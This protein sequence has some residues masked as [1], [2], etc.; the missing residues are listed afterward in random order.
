[1]M[2]GVKV[3]VTPGMIELGAKEKE[4]NKKFGEQIAE[5][6]EHNLFPGDPDQRLHQKHLRRDMCFRQGKIGIRE[7]RYTPLICYQCKR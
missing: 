4:Y 3:V 5:V 7:Y 2:P 6:A 1:M